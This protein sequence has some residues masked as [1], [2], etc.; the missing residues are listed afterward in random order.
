[1]PFRLTNAKYISQKS[2]NIV[3]HH[4][5]KIQQQ[6]PYSTI[7]LSIIHMIMLYFHIPMQIKEELSDE[8]YDEDDAMHLCCIPC[9]IVKEYHPFLWHKRFIGTEL[10]IKQ[11]INMQYFDPGD[12]GGEI[13]YG[14][15]K[16]KV[17]DYDEKRVD[18]KYWYID[19]E[20]SDSF[21][22]KQSPQWIDLTQYGL[23]YKMIPKGLA[24]GPPKYEMFP[25][26]NTNKRFME[27]MGEA[28]HDEWLENYLD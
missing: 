6:L 20:T 23:K 5:K 18:G 7:P 14:W 13:I 27:Q 4:I 15:I 11:E 2:K 25:I 26:L 21:P 28:Y 8:I 24:Y 17:E 9:E 19:I 12:E 22:I 1:M 10:Y 3:Y 16:A